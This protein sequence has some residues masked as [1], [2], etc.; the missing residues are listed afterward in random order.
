MTVLQRAWRDGGVRHFG[1]R[2]PHEETIYVL[3]WPK[4]PGPPPLTMLPAVSP[5]SMTITEPVK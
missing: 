1:I 3:G 4:G 5:P 2:K